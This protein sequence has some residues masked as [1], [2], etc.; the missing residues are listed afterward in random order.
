[1]KNEVMNGNFTFKKTL[2]SIVLPLAT[3]LALVGCG[4][5]GNSFRLKGSI[6]GMEVGE[7][8]IYNQ[9]VDN[10]RFDTLRIENGAFYYGGNAEE[11]TPYIIVFPNALEQVVFMGPGEE[12]EYEAV[13]NDLNNYRTKGSEENK[14][15]N[16]FR[17]ECQNE[18]YSSI[19]AKARTFISNHPNSVVSLYILDRYFVQNAQTTYKELNEVLETLRP[20]FAQNT[21]FMSLE[22]KVKAMKELNVGDTFPELKLKNKKGKA[23]LWKGSKSCPHTVFLCW[24]TWLSNSYDVMSKIRQ[25]SSDYNE[26]SLR[27]VAFS[28][29][30]E[31][32][33]WDNMTR[34]DSVSSIEHYID[35]RTFDSPVFKQLG[36][37]SLPTYYIIDK[38]HKIVE[39]GTDP[40]KMQSDIKKLV[41]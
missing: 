25:T 2:I 5:S 3:L 4:P 18:S 9:S 41:E 15:M 13:S 20:S 16:E 40:S 38:N 6:S 30:G 34:F 39:K 33:R 27:I 10:A 35:T 21:Y 36:V 23:D 7:I 26:N 22:G 24:A 32:D 31:Y 12:I 11:P 17:A 29:D 14:L 37:G 28:L 8:Y 1:M 19:Q